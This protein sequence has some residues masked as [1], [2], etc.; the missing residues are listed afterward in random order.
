[1]ICHTTRNVALLAGAAETKDTS[2]SQMDD[3]STTS[4]SNSSDLQPSTVTI[5]H[6]MFRERRRVNL[7]PEAANQQQQQRVKGDDEKNPE[8]ETILLSD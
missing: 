5:F 1:M 2:F 4:M 8:D 6:E 7:P 3:I